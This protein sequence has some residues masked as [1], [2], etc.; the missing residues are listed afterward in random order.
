MDQTPEYGVL[1]EYSENLVN[2]VLESLVETGFLE[3]SGG[4]YP[5]VA[6]APK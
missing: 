5:V 6:C 4:E 3:R 2:A 1:A